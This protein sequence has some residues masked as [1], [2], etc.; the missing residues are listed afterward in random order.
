M[1][2]M[3]RHFMK[4]V[5]LLTDIPSKIFPSIFLSVVRCLLFV[6]EYPLLFISFFF[7]V[8][9]F[10][11]FFPGLVL[12]NLYS[13]GIQQSSLGWARF[14]ILGYVPLMHY[15]FQYFIRL[16]RGTKSNRAAAR[17]DLNLTYGTL[18]YIWHY[19]HTRAG[20][21]PETLRSGFLPSQEWR[22]NMFI[23]VVPNLIWL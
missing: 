15:L 20:G 3:I 18:S 14:V 17:S 11:N 19:C 10:I 23:I 5:N 8:S 1:A 4:G 2:K 13:M 9:S 22:V 16:G 21:Y 7:F 6:G 12:D